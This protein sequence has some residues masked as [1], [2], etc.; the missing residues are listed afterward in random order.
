[1]SQQNA[2]KNEYPGR[3]KLTNELHSRPALDITAPSRISHFTY[4]S[5]ESGYKA[6]L[7]HI[8]ALCKEHSLPLPTEDAR[9]HVMDAGTFRLKWERH[10]EASSYTCYVDGASDTLFSQPAAE[11]LPKAWRDGIGGELLVAVN[12]DVIEGKKAR[13]GPSIPKLNDL[14]GAKP[15]VGGAIAA[16]KAEVWTSLRVHGDGYGRYLLINQGLNPS[17][18][19]RSVQRL[20]EIET[21]RML[22]L[23]SF[24]LARRVLGDIAGLEPQLH[25]VA[26]TLA[27]EDSTKR[28]DE[29]L[30]EQITDLAANIEHLISSTDYR[31]AASRAYHQIVLHRLEELKIERLEGHQR[32]STFLLKRL[33]PA[34]TTCQSVER[35]L[36]SL[37]ERVNRAANLLRT[38]VDLALQKQNQDLLQSMNKRTELQIRL[39]GLVEKFSIVAVAYY[40][41]SV[42]GYA[43]KGVKDWPLGLDA[44]TALAILAPLALVGTWLVFRRAKKS[45][46]KSDDD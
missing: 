27:M 25:H 32:L 36:K 3:L 13:K 42:I 12:M 4:L 44:K 28:S 21:Y 2:F 43:F 1:M 9:F 16:D 26:H 41:L 30:L 17:R 40:L 35:R 33:D 7:K 18:L 46:F 11:A 14:F 38:S 31:F 29:A 5:D 37:A 39:Q 45:I 6:D 22:A 20:M 15:I 24:P 8:T 10:L 23:T 34:M 19:G